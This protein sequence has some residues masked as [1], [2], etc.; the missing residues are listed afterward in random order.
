MGSFN[1]RT[2]L[3][4]VAAGGFATRVAFGADNRLPEPKGRLFFMNVEDGPLAG[5]FAYDFASKQWERV[6]DSVPTMTRARVSP[7]GKT[8][9]YW[10]Y[11]QDGI[12]ARARGIWTVDLTRETESKQVSDVDGRP[13]WAPDSKSLIVSGPVGINNPKFETWKVALPSGEKTRL[14]VPD[15]EIVVDWAPDGKHLVTYRGSHIF[16]RKADGTGPVEI[17][18]AD[19]M[20]NYRLTSDGGKVLYTELLDPNTRFGTDVRSLTGAGA[21]PKNVIEHTEGSAPKLFSISTDDAWLAVDYWEVLPK[22]DSPIPPGKRSLKLFSIDGKH[23]Q[24]VEIPHQGV[25][26]L[27]WR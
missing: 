22:G 27:D 9:A 8:L 26:P 7:D 21:E 20:F 25:I 24:D 4:I 1:R 6:A 17:G 5:I 18:K 15:D 14:A 12:Q 10:R 13:S 23:K 16:T 11:D 2:W 19:S 3:G